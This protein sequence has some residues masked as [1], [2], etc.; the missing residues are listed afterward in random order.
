MKTSKLES[1]ALL[2]NKSR[3]LPKVSK[4]NC[5][6]VKIKYLIERRSCFLPVTI[7]RDETDTKMDSMQQNLGK[8]I[9][10]SLPKDESKHFLNQ[11]YFN[12]IPLSSL[13]MK[14]FLSYVIAC[15]FTEKELHHIRTALKVFQNT[16]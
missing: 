11:W 14:S 3:F 4:N 5:F 1:K 10:H 9:M 13:P 15:A 7:I 8:Q 6:I 2:Q 12:I 16:V